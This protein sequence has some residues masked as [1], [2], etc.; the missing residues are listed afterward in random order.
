M[1]NPEHLNL[2]KQGVEEW[3]Q[4]REDNPRVQPDL[5]DAPLGGTNLIELNLSNADLRRADLVNAYL[6]GASL[7]SA[8]LMAANLSEADLFGVDLR[9]AILF[10]VDLREADLRETNL[11]EAK[12]RHV[13]LLGANLSE[14][15]LR[16]MDLSNSSLRDAN[17]SECDLRG[18]N[19]RDSDLGDANLSECD[20]RGANLSEAY[21]LGANLNK[22][23]LCKANLHGTNLSGF[24]LSGFDLRESD[25]SRVEVLGTNFEKSI[26]TGACLENWNINRETR[27]DGAIC[28]YVYLKANQ[29]E[30]RPR[31]GKF[32]PGEFVTLF[33]KAIDTVDLIFQDG[34]D[35]QAFFQSFRDLRSQ[36]A[37]D[38][39]SIQAIEKKRGDAF[40]IRVEVAE[41][42][43]KKAIEG[44]AK[45]LYETKLTLLE[46]RYRAELQAKDGEIVA[47][48]QQS[49]N[50]MKITE[51][52]AARPPMSETPK[53]D[54]RGAQFAGGYIGGNVEG[55]QIGGTINNYGSSAADITR[56]IT[57]LREHAQAFPDEQ[58]DEALDTLDD[59][60]GDLAK[61]E[62]DPGRIGRRLKRL[63]AIATAL[64]I[65]TT[66]FAA[67]LA[68]L[69][70]TLNV[71]LPKI[72]VE[73]VQPEQ[74]PPSN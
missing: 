44:S 11:N 31:K 25:F 24:D 51:I 32:K 5:C 48:K 66:G 49:A 41:G 7:I 9:E 40:I 19:L 42:S 59:L 20:L 62:P 30:R 60:E 26:L 35:W 71:P 47:Y 15:D 2:L 46:Q 10:G 22:A 33:Q 67:D 52:L 57:A 74:L 38:N 23:N 8:N 18:A 43:D 65:G 28:D 17:L 69:A 58:K 73:Q 36:Y 70:E 29:K 63:A 4:W 45:E 53:Y 64:T 56:L 13:N 61:A 16:G 39:L 50:L 72:Q 14:C 55:D 6:M 21:L 1:A 37:D 3:N 34:I 68:Q 27:L 12:L 54:F